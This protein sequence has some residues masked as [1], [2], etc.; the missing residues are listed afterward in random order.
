MQAHNIGITYRYLKNIQIFS[1]VPSA[2]PVDGGS[3]VHLLGDGFNPRS[4]GQGYMTCRFNS[5]VSMAIYVSNEESAC[6]SPEMPAGEVRL[7]LSNN[8][9]DFSTAGAIFT[10]TQMDLIEVW[11]THGPSNGG[12]VLEIHGQGL[13]VTKDVSCTFSFDDEVSPAA[14]ITS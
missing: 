7:E 8:H 3:L 5:S 9:Q 4:A 12:S 11:P 2:G 14:L 1:V 13:A 10:Y 6:Y